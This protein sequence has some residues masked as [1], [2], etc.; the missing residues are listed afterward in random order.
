MARTIVFHRQ[1]STYSII[2]NETDGGQRYFLQQ[3][4][5]TSFT[6]NVYAC[7]AG[8]RKD[9]DSTETVCR[10]GRRRNCCKSQRQQRYN[11]QHTGSRKHS[12]SQP[13]RLAE[14]I[15]GRGRGRRR[16]VSGLGRWRWN[17]VRLRK[18]LV[19]LLQRNNIQQCNCWLLF[20]WFLFNRTIFPEITLDWVPGIAQSNLQRVHRRK[21]KIAKAG[22]FSIDQTPFV[23]PNCNHWRTE[24][25]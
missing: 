9:G 24:G 17:A 12:T 2:D 22:I 10:G 18:I 19:T 14:L 5:S 3:Q 11:H 1:Q 20:F 8:R 13:R 6:E 16:M 25:V 15:A 23:S 21:F 7:S 4:H